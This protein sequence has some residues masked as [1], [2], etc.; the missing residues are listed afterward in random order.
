MTWGPGGCPVPLSVPEVNPGGQMERTPL[1]KDDKISPDIIKVRDWDIDVSYHR[2]REKWALT[3]DGSLIYTGKHLTHKTLWSRAGWKPVLD[4]R[5]YGGRN[6]LA[7]WSDGKGTRESLIAFRDAWREAG[8]PGP[9]LERAEIIFADT[10]GCAVRC[11]L[12]ELDDAGEV[13]ENKDLRYFHVVP[14]ALKIRLL[15][16]NGSLRDERR[17]YFREGD[18]SWVRKHGDIDPACWHLLMYEE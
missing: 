11:S 13:A 18:K 12:D 10:E 9:D 16:K 8:R 6:L 17:E 7:V 5:F 2:E 14:P 4:L 1:L 3:F 15:E